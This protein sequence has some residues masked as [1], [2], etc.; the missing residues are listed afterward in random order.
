[1]AGWT[2]RWPR[3]DP[4]WPTSERVSSVAVVLGLVRP[5]DR[6]ADVLRL[7]RRQLRQLRAEPAQVEPGDPLVQVLR[8]GHDVL[9]VLFRVLVQLQLRHHLV[10][11]DRKSV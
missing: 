10:G 1:M 11:E 9:A 8:Q 4:T 6:D 5:L 7:L 2:T 3:L